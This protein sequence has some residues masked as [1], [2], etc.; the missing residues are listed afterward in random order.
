[1]DW[2]DGAPFVTPFNIDALSEEIIKNLHRRRKWFKSNIILF[3]WVL[4]N[5]LFFF[6]F[7]K[8]KNIKI[9]EKKIIK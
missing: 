7:K 5:F 4:I 3:P 2:D 6:F 9:F 8:K 1:L